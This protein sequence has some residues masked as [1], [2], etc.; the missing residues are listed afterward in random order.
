MFVYLINLILREVTIVNDVNQIHKPVHKHSR[1]QEW[2]IP[3]E[4][5]VIISI[6]FVLITSIVLLLHTCS[7]ISSN[8]SQGAAICHSLEFNKLKRKSPI[9]LTL[10][11]CLLSYY[12]CS[13]KVM[14]NIKILV[15]TV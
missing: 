12:M 11:H 15:Q 6:Q 13:N 3:I 5:H 9:T 2:C 10:T 14:F 8:I 7:M 1:E 4:L